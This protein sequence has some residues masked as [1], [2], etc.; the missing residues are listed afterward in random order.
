MTR[1]WFLG[2]VAAFGLGVSCVSP[3]EAEDF[4][5]LYGTARKQARQISSNSLAVPMP[6]EQWQATLAERREQWREMLGLSPLPERTPLN[7]KVTGTLERGDYV[8][9]KV[10]FEAVPG[11]YVIGNLYRPAVITEPLPAVLYLCGHT[12]GKVSPTY[13]SH[14]RWFGQHGYVSLV[15]DPIQLGESQGL[16]HGTYR[17]G[18]WDWQSRGYTPAGTEVWNAMRAL[19]YLESRPDVDGDRMGVTG[20]SG[21]GVIS[22]CLGGA[23]ERVKVVVPV[24]QS[25]SIEQVVTDRSTDGHCDCAFWINYY[26]WCWSDIGSL[27]AP[28]PFLMASGSEDVLWRPSGY[29]DVAHRIRHQYT[30]LGAGDNFDLVED[31]SPHGYTP[32]LRRAI[33]TWFNTHLK[34]DPSPVADDVTDFVEPEENL[35]VFG[36]KLPTDDRM[37]EIDKILV[38]R[39]ELPEITDEKS[40]QSH[41]AA[42][43]AKLKGLTF[44][45]TTEQR[46]PH[47]RAFRDDGNSGGLTS[48]TYEFESY[49]GMTISV[50][51]KR[52]AGSPLPTP[53]LA[54]AAQPDAKSTFNGG[55]ASRPGVSAPIATA[56]V[57]VRNTGVTSVGPGYLWT[58]RRTYPL[59]GETL[60]ERQ[61]SDLLAGIALLRNQSQTGPIAVYGQGVT[62]PLAI[63]AAL[64]DDEITE[65]V[66]ANPPETHADPES[67]EFLGV[68]RIGDYPQNLALA[69]PRPITFVGKMPAAYEWTRQ[70]YQ[71][72]GAGDKIRVIPNM[73]QW[74]PR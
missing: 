65:I 46:T 39:P 57:E 26:R 67:G 42:A 27:I 20:L 5:T 6:P 69:Y 24:C 73:Q 25:G 48:G 66:L 32:K 8:V 71:K 58:A 29:R 37:R 31:L 61:L 47:H 44:R 19:D 43:L 64:L 17:E 28:R 16:H 74:Q 15:L 2:C 12:K 11:A 7:A 70:A 49:D 72:L 56:V 21:G 34:Q 23:D 18:R 30:A 4:T 40:W 38:R 68:L 41:Q 54:L 9:E 45:H 55:G 52:F 14:P 63:Y 1:R 13:Q 60:P 62:A 51:T 35:L 53:L 33:F 22:W 3:S 59:L 36:G 10:Y 50:R